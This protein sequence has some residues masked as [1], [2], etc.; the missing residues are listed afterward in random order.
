ME[1]TDLLTILL[2]WSV[3]SNI[4]LLWIFVETRRALALADEVLDLLDMKDHHAHT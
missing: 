4:F 3:F 1:L 2:I